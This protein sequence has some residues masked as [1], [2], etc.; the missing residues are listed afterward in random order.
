MTLKVWVAAGALAVGALAY[1]NVSG[2]HA[3]R[4]ADV[5]QYADSIAKLSTWKADS[6]KFAFQIRFDSA[7]GVTDSIR[8]SVAKVVAVA[9]HQTNAAIAAGNS[10]VADAKRLLA[11]TAATVAQLRGALVTD[12]AVIDSLGV[13]FGKE[14]DA[15]RLARVADST[16]HAN[17]TR[18]LRMGFTTTIA[19]KDSAARAVGLAFSAD[20]K[21]ASSSSFRKGGIVG[22]G[23]ALAVVALF[24]FAIK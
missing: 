13:A 11:D 19:A 18:L 1:A 6:V 7:A 23:V 5:R 3:Q 4:N 12:D 2:R 15:E 17:E 21:A 24:K 22:A 8:R 9:A 20:L 16:A 10:A 14:R